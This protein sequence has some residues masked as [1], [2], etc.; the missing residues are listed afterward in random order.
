MFQ[1]LLLGLKISLDTDTRIRTS[2]HTLDRWCELSNCLLSLLLWHCGNWTLHGHSMDSHLQLLLCDATHL[3]TL[4]HPPVLPVMGY[5][6]SNSSYSVVTSTFSLPPFLPL[7]CKLHV[8]YDEKSTQ[9]NSW[10]LDAN[11]TT[12]SGRSSRVQAVM[13]L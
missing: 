9:M 5:T 12:A 11:W 13:H 2:V 3:V 4:M 1:L 10:A 7:T 6:A 8:C